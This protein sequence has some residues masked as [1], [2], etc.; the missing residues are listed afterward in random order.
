[1]DNQRQ[2]NIAGWVIAE[3]SAFICCK[4]TKGYGV[5]TSRFSTNIEPTIKIKAYSGNH[6]VKIFF[7]ASVSKDKK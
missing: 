1:M 6:Q 2:Y 5:D 3:T 7:R 4:K